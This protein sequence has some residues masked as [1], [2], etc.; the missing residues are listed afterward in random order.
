LLGVI[1]EKDLLLARAA[2][3]DS[4]YIGDNPVVLNNRLDFG[5]YGNIGLAVKGIEIYLPLSSDLLLCAFCPSILSEQF[6]NNTIMRNNIR[7]ELQRNA[8]AG[9]ITFK[10]M[11][12][13][14]KE[15]E[16]SYERFDRIRENFIEG[17]PIE[18]TVENMRYYNSLQ[19][20]WSSRYVIDNRGDF[21]LGKKYISEFPEF[22]FGRK[23]SF[24]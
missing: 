22:K 1:A 12:E 17:R 20:Q 3:K 9:R 5:A 15:M 13:K 23:V 8:V 10:Q 24:G 16:R 6:R 7:T 14:V 19:L 2:D 18:S 11:G 21:R 4:F